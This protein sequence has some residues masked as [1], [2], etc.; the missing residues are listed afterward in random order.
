MVKYLKK[1]NKD[2]PV[3]TPKKIFSESLGKNIKT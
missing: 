3:N 2:T 1:I